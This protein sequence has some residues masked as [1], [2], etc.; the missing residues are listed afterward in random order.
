MIS[1]V[2]GDIINS[3]L[4]A[5]PHVYLNLLKKEFLSFGEAGKDWEIFRGDSFQFRIDD[6]SETLEKALIIKAAVKTIH[7]LDV[8]LAI[9]IGDI[10][11]EAKNLSECN[12]EAFI[13]A[14]EL[15]KKLNEEKLSFG[16]KSPWEELNA[17]I[18]LMLKLSIT[19]MD[20]WTVRHAEIIYHSLKNP[21]LNQNELGVIMGIKQSTVSN[22][23]SKARLSEVNELIKYFREKIRNASTL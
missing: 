20:E 23:K 18:N 7:N 11:Y 5:S 1:I 6:V 13:R 8:R 22:L 16:I 14:G 12:G 19:F 9:G 4:A 21:D 15:L 17:E 10:S 2:T 3:R